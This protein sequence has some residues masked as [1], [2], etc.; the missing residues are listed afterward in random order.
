MILEKRA[1]FQL[2]GPSRASFN[3]VFSWDDS[4]SSYGAFENDMEA[5]AQKFGAH[6]LYSEELENEQTPD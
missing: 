6:Y 2:A 3:M 5:L 4:D 1:Q